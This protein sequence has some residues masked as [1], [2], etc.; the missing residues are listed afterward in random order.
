MYQCKRCNATAQAPVDLRC[1]SCDPQLA[2]NSGLDPGAVIPRA[3][4]DI[5]DLS[6]PGEL[7]SQ[8]PSE[9]G[10]EGS[11]VEPQPSE[12]PDAA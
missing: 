11:P 6:D 1:A 7:A 8:P 9:S 12:D 3:E 4:S 10:V 5:V 2:L